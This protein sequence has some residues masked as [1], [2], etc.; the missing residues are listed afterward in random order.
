[1]KYLIALI[2]LTLGMEGVA[3]NS[4]TLEGIWKDKLFIPESVPGFNFLNDGRHYT[5]LEDNIIKKYDIT[6]GAY[7]DDIFDASDVSGQLGFNGDIEDYHF[8]A[9]ESK[10]LIE[11]QKEKIYRRSYTANYHVYSF[12]T[13]E[14]QALFEYGSV[15]NLSL[16]HI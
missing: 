3:Q 1:M 8:S 14:F 5:R 15:M 13:K 7:V 12:D 6:T 2:V 11:S 9:D 16:I 4:I 10:V